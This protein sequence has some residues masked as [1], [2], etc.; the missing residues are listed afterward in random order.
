MTR[1]NTHHRTR[2]VSLV[3][4]DIRLF[5]AALAEA[6]PEAR[7]YMEPTMKQCRRSSPPQLLIGTS[8]H[9]IWQAAHRLKSD[10]NMILDPTWEPAWH[11]HHEVA[12]WTFWPARHPY[13]SFRSLFGFVQ[14]RSGVT[15]IDARGDIAVYCDPGNEDHY[16]FAA[17][18]YRL[19]SKFASNRHLI[20]V[21]HPSGE[22][23]EAYIDRGAWRWVGHEARRWAA[24]DP[25]RYLTFR[26]DNL[27]LRPA[28]E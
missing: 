5:S 8:L 14:P 9:R 28:D 2:A 15:A 10:V 22:V 21:K 17:R 25:N 26:V 27:G 12:C 1:K 7:Y 13:V 3:P 16:R 24:E 19:F 6:Y 4:D 23:T 20:E 11:V 18:F